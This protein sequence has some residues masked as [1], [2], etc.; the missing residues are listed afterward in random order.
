MIQGLDVL[1]NGA[2]V[3]LQGDVIY[4]SQKKTRRIVTAMNLWFAD[5]ENTEE[6]KKKER[7]TAVSRRQRLF[8]GATPR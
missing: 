7:K 1:R 8:L 6:R 5:T 2:P 4:S 3:I